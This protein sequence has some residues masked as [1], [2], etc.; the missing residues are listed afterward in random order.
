M[1][2][3]DAKAVGDRTTGLT[4]LQRKE[5]AVALLGERDP[6]KIRGWAREERTALDLLMGLLSHPE[7]RIR[8]RAVEALGVAAAVRSS[9]DM[10]AV[11]DRIRRLLW[12]MNH[13]SGNLIWLAPDAAAEM[14]ASVPELAQEYARIIASF[15]GLEPFVQGVHRAVA[16]MA[17]VRPETV[18][19]LA[20]YLE[21]ALGKPD[22]EVRAYA[23]L[24]LACID[25]SRAP[26]IRD[27]LGRDVES[28]SVYDRATG[29][30]VTTSVGELVS[31]RPSCP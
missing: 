13:E 12:S 17:R 23:A 20:P 25:P 4:R 26:A 16:R 14:I 27:R 11:R 15:I 19:Y 29:R 10:N 2:A 7:D 3:S 28:L 9:E 8:W 24:A 21:H 5:R 31:S 18:A 6:G 1:F 22:P 30:I